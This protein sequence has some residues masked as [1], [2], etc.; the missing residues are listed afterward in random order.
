LGTLVAP[1][2]FGDARKVLGLPYSRV[3]RLDGQRR[4]GIRLRLRT[5]LSKVRAGAMRRSTLMP[6]DA[7]VTSATG[8]VAVI[9][10][11]ST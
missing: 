10:D 5:L 3:R 9:V 1:S 8:R 7:P 6:V 2:R 11:S 4:L